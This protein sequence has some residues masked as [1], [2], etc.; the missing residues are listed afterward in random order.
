MHR[1][2]FRLPP[3][4]STVVGFVCWFASGV[5]RF[6]GPA[7]TKGRTVCVASGGALVGLGGG[8]YFGGGGGRGKDVVCAV[9]FL[10]RRGKKKQTT[11][12]GP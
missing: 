12:Q 2:P 6:G 7:K 9:R 1:F 11:P 10:P 4:K 8:C 3:V 5:P